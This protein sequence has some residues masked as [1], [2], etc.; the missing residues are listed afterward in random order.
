MRSEFLRPR[1]PVPRHTGTTVA[2]CPGTGSERWPSPT[3]PFL[4]L[5]LCFR[6]GGAE[7]V[8]LG[9]FGLASPSI[10]A[11]AQSGGLGESQ[12]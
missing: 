1:R 9:H 3:S 11:A 7:F 12:K 5:A 10:V 4:D 8:G 6:A 2:T